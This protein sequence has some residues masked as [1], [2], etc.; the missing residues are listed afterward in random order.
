MMDVMSGG[1]P[2]TRSPRRRVPDSAAGGTW[3]LSDADLHLFNEG[4]HRGLA[5]KLGAHPLGQRGTAFA[6]W[7]P[8]ARAVS[9]IGDFN[10]W[11]PA[12]HPLHP[13]ASSGIWSGIVDDAAPGHLY[14]YAVTTASG[15]VL[16]KAD[17]YASASECPPRTGSLVWDLSYDWGD[18]EWMSTRAGRSALGAPMAIYEVHL[19]SWRRPP[20]RPDAFLGYEELARTS[21]RTCSSPASPTSS[22]CP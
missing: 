8:N 16:E 15:T 12:A 13:V 7:A 4:T 18:A 6:V 21:S 14:K 17:P 10:G 22:S 9:A 1:A 5:A 19:G 20:G 3:P 2:V 11:D